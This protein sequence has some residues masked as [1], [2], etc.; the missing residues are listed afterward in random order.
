MLLKAIREH[1]GVNWPIRCSA[2]EKQP[3]RVIRLRQSRTGAETWKLREQLREDGRQQEL[4]IGQ[5]EVVIAGSF[6]D[7]VASNR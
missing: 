1:T 5:A 7:L 3:G 6:G 2:R 4:V